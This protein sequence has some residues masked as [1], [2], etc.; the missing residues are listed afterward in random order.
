VA[1]PADA[2]SPGRFSE[3]YELAA[4]IDLLVKDRRN[5]IGELAVPVSRPVV[6]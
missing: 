6:A 2:L 5:R 1:R 3:A 4:G